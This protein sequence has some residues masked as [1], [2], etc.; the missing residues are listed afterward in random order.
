MQ[1]FVNYYR[2]SAINW[3]QEA[4]SFVRS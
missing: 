2:L 3:L 1:I 4:E